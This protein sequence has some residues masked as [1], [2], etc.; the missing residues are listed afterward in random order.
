MD[1]LT[2]LVAA[3]TVH[4]RE[5]ASASHRPHGGNLSLEHG[6][7]DGSCCRLRPGW[8]GAGALL[9]R[10]R[11]P[12]FRFGQLGCDLVEQRGL[13]RLPGPSL[14]AVRNASSCPGRGMCRPAATSCAARFEAAQQDR[15]PHLRGLQLQHLITNMLAAGDPLAE[16]QRE[17]EHGL[18]FA[19]KAAVRSCRRPHHRAAR[20]RPDAARPDA[21]LRLLQRCA[22]RRAAVRAASGRGPG[23]GVCRLLVLDPQA[24]GTLPRRRPRCRPRRRPRRRNACSGCRHP[25]SRWPTIISTPRWRTPRSATRPQLT[26]RQQH[27]EALAAH[28]R[29]LDDLGR[30]LPGELREPRRAGRRRDRPPRRPRARRRCAFTNRPSARPATT[31]SCTTRRSP[32]SW[33]RASMPAAASRQIAHAHLRNAPACYLRWGADGKVRQLDE[34]YPHLREE[35]P[36]PGPTRTIGAPVE[37]LDLATVIKV[38]QAVSGEIVLEKLIDTLMRT[39]IEQAGAERGLLILVARDRASASRRRPRPAARRSSCICATRA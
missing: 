9:R 12:R 36:A 11:R 13:D 37:H 27:L 31:A 17:A 24:A 2:S 32:M 30:A 3:G 20:A 16:V 38:S 34:L 5:P 39:A 26:E 33:P 35:E 19:R 23:S 10:L 14:L 8:Q 18:D 1:V 4:R 15:R 6:N 7:S 29:Q 25:S 28:H 21:D 22:V